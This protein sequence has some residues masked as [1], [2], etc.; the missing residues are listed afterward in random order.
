ME[1]RKMWWIDN[2]LFCL[3]K[4]CAACMLWLCSSVQNPFVVMKRAFGV[5]IEDWRPTPCPNP[6]NPW[7][8]VFSLLGRNCHQ[9]RSTAHE[10]KAKPKGVPHNFTFPQATVSCWTLNNTF[11]PITYHDWTLNGYSRFLRANT[12]QTNDAG[13]YSLFGT[14][15]LDFGL[16]PRLDIPFPNPK[17]HFVGRYLEMICRHATV[18]QVLH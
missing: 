14:G 2:Y 6:P 3:P 18:F 9:W 13:H 15:L 8:E 12:S 7:H 4:L 1:R 11:T 17:R 10:E 16:Q 5:S